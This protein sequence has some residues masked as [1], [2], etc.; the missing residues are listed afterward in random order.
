MIGRLL[1]LLG[2]HDYEENNV[3]DWRIGDGHPSRWRNAGVRDVEYQCQRD[4]CSAC[5]ERREYRS[6]SA[7]RR[8]E[9]TRPPR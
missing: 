1:C 3:V 6:K 9:R 4:G 5:V 7:R 2:L 8:F